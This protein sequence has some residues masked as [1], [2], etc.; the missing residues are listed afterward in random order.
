LKR[1]NSWYKVTR[2]DIIQKGGS[3]LLNKYG[4]SPSKLIQTVYPE[5]DWKMEKFNTPRNTSK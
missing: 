5:H 1:M 2:N 4:N 3:G